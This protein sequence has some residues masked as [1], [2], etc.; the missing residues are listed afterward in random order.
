[1]AE[2]EYVASKIQNN[3]S[4]VGNLWK[5]I[6]RNYDFVIVTEKPQWGVFN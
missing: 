3:P 5:I 6:R 1:M 2:K 4:N